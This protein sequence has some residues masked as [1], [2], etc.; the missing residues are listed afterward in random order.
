MKH[1]KRVLV[2]SDI[3]G[4]PVKLTFSETGPNYRTA[5]GG[6]MSLFV[7][8]VLLAFFANNTMKMVNRADVKTITT[9]MQSPDP[10]FVSYNETEMEIV[11]TVYDYK[12]LRL[13]TVKE[14]ENI[15]NIYVSPYIV[16]NDDF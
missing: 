6:L 8:S 5:F 13:L 12:K 2:A 10:L 11:L 9:E 4:L 16:K 15:F 3:F 1:V 14:I 7:V